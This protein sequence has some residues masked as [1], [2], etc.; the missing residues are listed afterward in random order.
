MKWKLIYKTS[1]DAAH[2]LNL[3]YESKCKN[4][5]GHTWKI[6]VFIESPELDENGMVIDFQVLK[7]IIHELD[8][9]CLNDF[10]NQPTCEKLAEF[11][12]QRIKP[13][14]KESMKLEIKVCESP[15]SCVIYED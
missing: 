6:F 1:I 10:L 14:L 3:P 7:K 9:K 4:L 12:Y 13:Y 8:H 5:H 2:F 11:L 15:N